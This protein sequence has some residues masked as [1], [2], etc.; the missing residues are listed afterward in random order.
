MMD[1]EL[2]L[3]MLLLAFAVL[4]LWV[5]FVGMIAKEIF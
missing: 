3:D 2:W 1:R 5:Q 4:M